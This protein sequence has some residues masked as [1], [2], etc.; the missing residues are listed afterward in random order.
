VGVDGRCFWHGA[1]R[2]AG[3]VDCR[4]GNDGGKDEQRGNIDFG[5]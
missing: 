3:A 5:D 2:S 1:E 4:G